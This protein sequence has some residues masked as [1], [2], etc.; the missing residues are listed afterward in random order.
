M[1]SHGDPAIHTTQIPAQRPSLDT[2]E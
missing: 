2:Q 1:L